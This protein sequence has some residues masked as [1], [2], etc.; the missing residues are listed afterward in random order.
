MQK[1]SAFFV[2]PFIKQKLS[3]F[4]TKVHF[5]DKVFKLDDLLNAQLAKCAKT[6]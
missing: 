1:K 6:N 2:C 3:F 5:L 4:L